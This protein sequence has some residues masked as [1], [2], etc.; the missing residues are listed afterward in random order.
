MAD[1]LCSLSLTFMWLA[2]I[3]K[4]QLLV[5]RETT[6]RKKNKNDQLGAF[7]AHQA[8]VQEIFSYLDLDGSGRSRAHASRWG[9]WVGWEA[10]ELYARR[11]VKKTQGKHMVFF[12]KNIPTKPK[13]TSSG[14]IIFYDTPLVLLD[15][16][17]E[18]IF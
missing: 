13:R 14:D 8:E 6:S 5:L 10:W 4:N 11:H 2:T 7:T 9:G 3:P 1:N 18:P 16:V 15:M 17:V 12:V